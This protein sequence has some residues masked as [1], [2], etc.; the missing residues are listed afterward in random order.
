VVKYFAFILALGLAAASAAPA[1]VLVW[2]RDNGRTF[3]D[4]DGSGVVGTEHALMRA[5]KASGVTDAERKF[6]LPYDLGGYDAVFVLCGFW[7][8][9]GRLSYTEK[10]ILESYLDRDGANLYLEGTEVG[11]RYGSSALFKKLGA[12]FA[13]DG[14]PME[15]GN[16]N[17]AEGVGA[18]AGIRFD[19]YAYRADEPDAFVD[20]FNAAGGEVVVRSRR[21]GNQS[22]ARV[23]RYAAAGEAN[24]KA[25]TSS[26]IFGAL[27]NGV[28]M[29]KDLMAKYVEFFGLIGGNNK[30]SVAP[31]SLGR[32][33]TL[34]R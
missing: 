24:Y 34:F 23:V 16:V 15:D 22:N 26:L 4:P 9:D 31:A 21:A 29:K 1:K 5:L 28:Y 10:R 20:E 13:D 8:D 25:I 11:R 27:K 33:R 6:V 18:W 14:R 7:P 2:D 12:A 19:Y 32:V 3:D 30:I 17:V